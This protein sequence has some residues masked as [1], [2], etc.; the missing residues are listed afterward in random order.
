[1]NFPHVTQHLAAMALSQPSQEHIAC[2]LSSKRW[3]PHQVW[4][5]LHPFQSQFCHQWAKLAVTP[6]TDII[7]VRHQSLSDGTAILWTHNLHCE[8]STE[9]LSAPRQQ[10]AQG[11]FPDSL[12]TSC[13]RRRSGTW[14]SSFWYGVFYF[15]CQPSM[16]WAWRYTPPGCPATMSTRSSA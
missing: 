10:T 1:M 4:C 9:M 2:H 16:P 11:Y 13:Q 12:R 14:F 15:P 8:R 3:P 6:G 5:R 7:L